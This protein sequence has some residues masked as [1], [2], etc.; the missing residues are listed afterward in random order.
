M[1]FKDFT[2]GKVFCA[3]PRAVTEEEIIEFARRYDPQPFHVDPE[4]AAASRWGGLISSGWLTC[5]IAME[6]AVKH[7][8]GESDSI[9]SPGLEE[10]KWERPVRPGD[11]LRLC[12]TVL[13][14]RLS[15]SGS[16][17]VV[18]WR[19][20]LR[21]QTGVRVLHMIAT[22]LFNVPAPAPNG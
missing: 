19:W 7:V 13:E 17:G 6:L 12:L 8:L 14:S 20:E 9:G 11:A 10:V 16:V 21:N 15:S 2:A 18:R 1:H 5:C 22:S 4:K 3:G